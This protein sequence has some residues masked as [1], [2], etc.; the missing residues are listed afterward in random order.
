[1]IKN[2]VPTP[3]RSTNTA[4]P[5]R[6]S[7][8]PFLWDLR[9]DPLKLMTDLAHSYGDLAHVR[10]ANRDLVLVSHPDLIHELLVINHRQLIK[11]PALRRARRVLGNGLLTNEGAE[12]LNRRRLLQPAFHRAK[13]AAYGAAMVEHAARVSHAWQHGQELDLS[14]QMAALTLAIAGQTMFGADVSNDADAVG[15]ALGDLMNLFGLLTMPFGEWLMRLPIPASRRLRAAQER[16]DLVIDRMIAERRASD[17]HEDMLAM[18]L[19]AHDQDGTQLSDQEVRDEALTLFLAGHETTAN[20]LA[21]TWYLL[22]LHPAAEQRMHTELA[23]VLQ[24]RPASSA[25]L[26]KLPYTR[27]VF[28]EALRLRPPAWVVGRETTAPITLGGQPI[29]A[30][31]TILA[32]QWVTH[33]DGRFFP[34]PERFMPERW[35]SENP[36]RPRLAFFPFGAGPRMC[37]G[38]SFAWMEGVLVL[39]TIAQHWQFRLTRPD[40]ITPQPGV[41]LRIRGGLPMQAQRRNDYHP[42]SAGL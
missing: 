31:A 22:A 1:M 13:V 21:W 33:R 34:Q 30:G 10:V 19:A 32:S 15:H 26:D 35:L 27:A 25:D 36:Q 41:T 23:K 3:I 11:G 39:A 9:R 37:I 16:L 5:A 6:I 40:R 29:P 20:A 42:A 38:E 24:G 7:P 12:H 4:Q 14:D 17:H 8:V 2:T 28:S 18:L